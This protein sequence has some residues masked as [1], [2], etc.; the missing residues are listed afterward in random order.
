[1]PLD[2]ERTPAGNVRLVY[3]RFVEPEAIVL[4][5]E[6]LEAARIAHELDVRQGLTEEPELR[7]YV[8]H[9]ATCPRA[10]EWAPR[11]RRSSSSRPAA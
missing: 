8:H 7:L 11:R 5:K 6:E 3:G 1:M 9:R 2:A 10:S 4:R